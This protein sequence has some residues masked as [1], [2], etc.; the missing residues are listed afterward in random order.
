M[1]SVLQSFHAVV[2]SVVELSV[3]AV[4]VGVVGAAV[5]AV[6]VVVVEVVGVGAAAVVGNKQLTSSA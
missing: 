5:A 6:G 1:A 4:A 3:L 2:P